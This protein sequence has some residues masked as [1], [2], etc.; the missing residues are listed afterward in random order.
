VPRVEFACCR[1]RCDG[2]LMVAWLNRAAL[3]LLSGPA[4][5]TGCQLVH[6]HGIGNLPPHIVAEVFTCRDRATWYGLHPGRRQR[7]LM[8][9]SSLSCE[10]ETCRA[11]RRLVEGGSSSRE[12]VREAPNCREKDVFPVM[13]LT[14]VFSPPRLES[15][16]SRCQWCQKTTF[17]EGL[18]RR[19]RGP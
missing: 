16:T 12:L 9:M 11:R 5:R 2:D 10:A 3:R 15:W 19:Q 4:A 8:R 14:R 1:V 7:V 13:V 18:S 6:L 17:Q